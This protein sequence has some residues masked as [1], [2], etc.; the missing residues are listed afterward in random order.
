MTPEVCIWGIDPSTTAIGVAL[1]SSN[2]SFTCTIKGYRLLSWWQRAVEMCLSLELLVYATIPG[3]P[4]QN[5]I[6]AIEMPTVYNSRGNIAVK[7]GD[8]R[9]MVMHMFDRVYGSYL[10]TAPNIAPGTLKKK[11][12]GKGNASKEMMVA[13]AE[14]WWIGSPGSEHEADALAVAM[15]ALEEFNA[16]ET[17]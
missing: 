11:L 5:T 15:V 13:C 7:L 17:Q 3:A 14:K 9:G 12:T 16:R 4:T 10:V 6:L 8:V 1:L 2:V